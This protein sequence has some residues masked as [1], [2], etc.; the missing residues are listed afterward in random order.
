MLSKDMR[1]IL[2]SLIIFF[3]S[4]ITSNNYCLASGRVDVN[5]GVTVSPA[6]VTIDEYFDVS[7]S[8]K[9]YQGE[10]KTLEYVELWM[11]DGNGQDLWRVHRWDTSDRVSF[12]PYEQKNYNVT[13]SL[14]SA[15]GRQP[16]TYRLIVRGNFTAGTDP[17]NFGVVSGSGASNPRIFSAVAQA[18]GRVDVNGGVTVSPATVTI[19]EYFD[20]S[21]SLKEYQGESKTLEYVELWMQDGNGQDLWK[22]HRWDTSDRVSF[23]PYE[24]K[25]YTVTTSLSSTYGRQPGTYRLIVRGNFTAGTDPFNFGV[26]SGSG[27]SN[28]RIF[29]AVAQASGRVDVYGGVTVSPSTPIIDKDFSISFSLKEYQ[30]ESKTLEYVEL[31]MQ[32]GNG[33][34]LWRIER[35]NNVSFTPYEEKYYSVT[36]SL[37]SSYGRQPGTYRAIVRGNFTPGTDPF[38][39]EVVPGSGAE[40]PKYFNMVANTIHIYQSP[41]EGIAGQTF[42]QSGSGFTPNSTVTLHVSRESEPAHAL[43]E[44]PVTDATGAFSTYYVSSPDKPI[45]TYTWWAVDDSTGRT[46]ETMRYNIIEHQENTTSAE[47]KNNPAEL[48]APVVLWGNNFTGILSREGT[49]DQNKETFVIVHGWNTENGKT[50]LPKWVLE[51]GRTIKENISSPARTSNVFYWNWQER[52]ETDSIWID[53]LLDK[54]MLN[55]NSLHIKDQS[56]TGISTRIINDGRGVPYDQTK[57]AGISLARALRN[58]LPSGYNHNI[59]LIGHSLG[60]LVITYAAESATKHNYGY[61]SHISHIVYLDSPCYNGKPGSDFLKNLKKGKDIFFEN[62]ISIFGRRYKDADV[63]VWLTKAPTTFGT[64][65]GAHG[66]SHLWYTSSITNFDNPSILHSFSSPSE[67]LHWGFYWWDKNNRNGIKKD[68]KQK[69]L[70]EH[71][72]LYPGYPGKIVSHLSWRVEAGLLVD[73]VH[74]KGHMDHKLYNWLNDYAIWSGNNVTILKANTMDVIEDVQDFSV[75]MPWHAAYNDFGFMELT[76]SSTAIMS[77]PVTIPEGANALSFSFQ[78]LYGSSDS[79]LEVFINDKPAWF[80]TSGSIALYEELQLIP[81]I[82]VSQYAGTTINLNIRVSHPEN[83]AEGK[84]KIDDLIVAKLSPPKAFPWGM[85][86]AAIS[87]SKHNNATPVRCDNNHLYLC[88]NQGQ[89]SSFGGYWYNNSCN[90]TPQCNSTNLSYCNN[91]G[92]CSSAGGY[93]Y[94]NNCNSVQEGC[95]PNLPSPVLSLSDTERYDA[96]GFHWIRYRL[97]VENKNEFPAELFAPSPNLP[98]CG[99]NTN[100]SRTWVTV[101]NGAHQPLKGFCGLNSL[102][103]F[104]FATQTNSEPPSSVYVELNDRK[105]NKKYF[106]T[107]IQVPSRRADVNADGRITTFDANLVSRFLQGDD[108]SQTGWVSEGPHVGDVNCSNSVEQEDADLL[109]RYSLG[110]DMSSTNWCLP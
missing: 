1:I 8:L 13:T 10:S 93:W 51:M 31:W 65:T 34:D 44:H 107:T 37:L 100:S 41:N 57:Y 98:P 60:T 50:D 35:W 56:C 53:K 106:S 99:A 69:D 47:Q 43:T 68:Y 75:D 14:S 32:D 72:R 5:G 88:R 62:Y 82:D 55:G 77:M 70:H 58:S 76:H 95:Y 109:L 66:Y 48:H 30:G 96:N 104:W 12:S 94:N 92:A 103:S 27:A 4:I 71:Y 67:E 33:Q 38:N 52:A 42:I 110:L 91:S 39:F 7:F 16:G 79:T 23:S 83:G 78:F 90:K 20:V 26:V 28:P 84:V 63:N 81:W 11:Q 18:S 80:H 59:H 102:D 86:N 49:F 61:A 29:S 25:N 46:S 6:T 74:V 87:A 19:D 108:M 97:T 17:F 2:T 15:Y 9:E 64:L 54:I 21:F 89:C 85:F 73:A 105:C 24:Q 36:T 3:L 101:Y 40:N 45:G 22:V